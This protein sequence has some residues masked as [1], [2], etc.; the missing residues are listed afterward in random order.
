MSGTNINI[1]K[2]KISSG[3][4]HG[5]MTDSLKNGKMNLAAVFQIG[6]VEAM[7]TLGT[8]ERKII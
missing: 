5:Y 2:M 4:I 8:T 1:L 7:K 3:R 6:G